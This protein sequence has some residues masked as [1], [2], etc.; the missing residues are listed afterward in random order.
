MAQDCGLNLE[1]LKGS[2]AKSTGRTGIFDPGP[3]DRD[4]EDQIGSAHILIGAVDS[5][6]SGSGRK[7]ATA[8]ALVAGK[9]FPRRRLAGD[10]QSGVPVAG[11][12]SGLALGLVRGMRS[13]LGLRAGLDRGS[14]GVRDGAGCARRSI[15]GARGARRARAAYGL[16]GVAQT[17]AWSSG[18]LTEGL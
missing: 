16:I 1:K 2:L 13:P 3:S 17:E 10:A 9:P 18:M 14:G 15:D 8:A 6:S 11:L 12:D 5:G 4:L 7:G